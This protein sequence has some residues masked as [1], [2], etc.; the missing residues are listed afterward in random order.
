MHTCCSST[1]QVAWS[2]PACRQ[3]RPMRN[4]QIPPRTSCYHPKSFKPP[5]RGTVLTSK[6]ISSDTTYTRL[7]MTTNPPPTSHHDQTKQHPHLQGSKLQPHP[8]PL[9]ALIPP[10]NNDKPHEPQNTCIHTVHNEQTSLI[11]THPPSPTG[12]ALL[13]ERGGLEIAS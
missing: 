8:Y 1:S 2:R 5:R 3:Y 10:S 9:T 4:S 6:S 7:H 12:E 11:L 13:K